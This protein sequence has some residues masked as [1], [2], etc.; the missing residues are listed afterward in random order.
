VN[1][2]YVEDLEKHGMLCTGRN[3]QTGLVET[4]E[5]EDHPWFIGVQFHP[6]YKSTV[7][8]PHPLFLSFIEAAKTYQQTRY[9]APS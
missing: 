8:T 2:Q 1:T 5:L 4:I 6:E 3:P 9:S 7:A